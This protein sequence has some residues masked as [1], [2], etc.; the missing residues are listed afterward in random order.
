MPTNKIVLQTQEEFIAD[1]TP[2]YEPIYG[3]LLGNAVA[4]TEEVGQVKFNR[5]EAVGDIRARR[6]TPKDTTIKQIAVKSGSRKFTKAFYANQYVQSLLQDQSE[7]NTVVAQVLDEHSR[8]FD[9]N[10]FLGEGTSPSTAINNSL[11]HSQDPYYDLRSSTA[12]SAPTADTADYYSKLM[13]IMDAADRV[14]GRKAILVYGSTAQSRLNTLFPSSTDSL[15]SVLEGAI[16]EDDRIIKVP[17]DINLGNVNGWIVVSLDHVKLHHCGLPK[18]D[19][20][21]T[22]EEKKYTW[23]NFLMGTSMVELLKDDAVIRQPLTF[24]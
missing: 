8:Q 1:F 22:N 24:S 3:I 17:A 9:E 12:I 11:F 21:G 7:I 23:H 6:L 18:L 4:Y 16:D 14:P 10:M 5:V 2:S 19:G 20:Q 13:A 15:R